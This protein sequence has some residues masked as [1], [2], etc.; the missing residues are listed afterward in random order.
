MSILAWLI[1]SRLGRMVA[2]GGLT[3]I[4]IGVMLLA[5]FRKGVRRERLKQ[6]AATAKAIQSRIKIDERVRKMPASDRRRELD[7]WVRG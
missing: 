6:I 3:A 5:A 1:G 2:G 7:K 4:M